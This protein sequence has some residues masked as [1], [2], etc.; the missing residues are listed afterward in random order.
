MAAGCST[1]E[2]VTKGTASA[3]GEDRSLPEVVGE[4]LG[5]VVGGERCACTRI[6]ESCG[7]Q[8]SSGGGWSGPDRVHAVCARPCRFKVGRGGAGRGGAG[9]D[10]GR[11]AFA[12]KKCFL[13]S[14]VALRICSESA[15]IFFAIR[16]CTQPAKLP[17]M[18]TRTRTRTSGRL[19][20]HIKR[21][22]RETASPE[23]A[24]ATPV[25]SGSS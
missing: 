1:C 21:L 12:S 8:T 22:N 20:Q 9:R 25:A 16:A 18:C 23:L 15:N 6:G 3:A 11:E 10:G 13:A 14:T 2:L 4:V 19:L 17:A 7:E 24:P 5:D